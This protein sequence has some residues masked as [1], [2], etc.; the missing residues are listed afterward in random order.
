MIQVTERCEVHRNYLLQLAPKRAVDQAA[1]RT[2]L[3]FPSLLIHKAA[4]ISIILV[5][6][7]T[8]DFLTKRTVVALFFE[9]TRRWK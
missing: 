5:E 4:I 9:D 7:H 2:L 8:L 1:F 3:L 6:V